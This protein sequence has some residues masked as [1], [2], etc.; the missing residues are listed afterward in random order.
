ME[1]I[2]PICGLE[3]KNTS[4][5][6]REDFNV[7]KEYLQGKK[8]G[9]KKGDISPQSAATV[10]NIVNYLHMTKEKDEDILVFESEKSN[11]EVGF[12][13]DS[14]TFD[15]IGRN[16]DA[17]CFMSM[18][19]TQKLRVHPFNIFQGADS[20]RNCVITLYEQQNL[21]RQ[22][23]GMKILVKGIERA[24]NVNITGDLKSLDQSM[25]RQIGSPKSLTIH[26]V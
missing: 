6:Q 11:L 12:Y 1:S 19:N 20:K 18:S 14:A 25:G 22:L 4:H 2:C 7:R 17:F 15:G 13:S 8:Q 23:N 3:L 24:I 21:L 5:V 16:I 9:G 10:K 26:T